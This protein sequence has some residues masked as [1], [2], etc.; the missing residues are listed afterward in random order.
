MLSKL[1]RKFD[2]K[3]GFTYYKINTCSDLLWLYLSACESCCSWVPAKARYILK[4]RLPNCGVARYGNHHISEIFSY[5]SA[6]SSFPLFDF[7]DFL[8]FLVFSDFFSNGCGTSTLL[9]DDVDT[10]FPWLGLIPSGSISLALR[11][12]IRESSSSFACAEAF[13]R[14][15]CRAR[16]RSYR[17]LPACEVDSQHRL[18]C[19]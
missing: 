14:S 19:F 5:Y 1:L 18:H 4:L 7:F 8:S 15:S 10:A 9:S 16:S 3:L 17:W 12:A 11:L 6:A 2:N 13:V